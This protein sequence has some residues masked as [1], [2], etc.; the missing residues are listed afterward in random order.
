MEGGTDAQTAFYEQMA[1][2][3]FYE[4]HQG[5]DFWGGHYKG[6][7]AMRY[8]LIVM[9]YSLR[10]APPLHLYFLYS[11]LTFANIKTSAVYHRKGEAGIQESTR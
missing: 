8:V 7:C 3:A 2:S 10:D 4:W 9:C 5:L 1:I 11:Y 6:K